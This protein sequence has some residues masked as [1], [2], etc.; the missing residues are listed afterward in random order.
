MPNCRNVKRRKL[1]IYVFI[2][3]VSALENH[4]YKP[5]YDGDHLVSLSVSTVLEALL[6]IYY[7]FLRATFLFIITRARLRTN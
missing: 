4:L 6:L 2:G 5:N 7:P 3:D 1:D